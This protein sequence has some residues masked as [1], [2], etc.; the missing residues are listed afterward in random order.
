MNKI[1]NGKKVGEIFETKDYSIFKFREDNRLVNT[2][3]VKKLANRM[4]ERGWLSSSVVTLNGSG[5]VIDGQHRVKAAIS[6]GAPIRYKVTRGAGSEEM[7]EMNTL[8]K[9]WSPFDHLHKWVSKGNSNY[10]TFD[11]F[12]KDFYKLPRPG[13]LACEV[14]RRAWPKSDLCQYQYC[15][16][17]IRQFLLSCAFLSPNPHLPVLSLEP[18]CR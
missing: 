17:S 11:K 12:V 3:H 15:K 18:V 6:V 1:Q 13:R 8:Q 10:I 2:N 4:K 16:K 5:E 9:N 7:T 14:T